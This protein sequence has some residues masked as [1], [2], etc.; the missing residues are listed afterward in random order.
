VNCFICGGENFPGA[1][2]CQSCSAPIQ[3]S[4]PVEAKMAGSASAKV[5]PS[6]MD[7]LFEQK[8][9]SSSPQ[10]VISPQPVESSPLVESKLAAPEVAKKKEVQLE[11]W[12]MEVV[13]EPPAP[14]SATRTQVS[15]ILWVLIASAIGAVAG[16]AYVYFGREPIVPAHIQIPVTV[17]PV[18]R[19]PRIVRPAIPNTLPMPPQAVSPTANVDP[20]ISPSINP[21]TSNISVDSKAEETKST[22]AQPELKR[23]KSHSGEKHS[24]SASERNITQPIESNVPL[25]SPAAP[26][27]PV[28]VSVA[29]LPLARELDGCHEQG[30]FAKVMCVEKA[31]WKF[32]NVN[33]VWD[34]SKPGCEVN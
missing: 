11:N 8:A 16:G 1:Q 29:K 10:P 21:P 6:I 33:G 22:N 31:R 4:T 34:N 15:P 26:K 17:A 23:A 12:D 28:E 32:C 2:L 18:I 30:G 27:T 13:D 14:S 20:G 3:S 19:K 7:R 5:E 24:P 9:S 25:E